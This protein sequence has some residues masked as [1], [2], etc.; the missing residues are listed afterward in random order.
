M[1]KEI[2][3]LR[4]KGLP[5]QAIGDKFGLS[6]E[7]VRQ[8]LL[9]DKYKAKRRE[10]RREYAKTPKQREYQ[11]EYDKTPK[12]RE[13]RREYDKTPKRREYQ[14]HRYH[15]KVNKQFANCNKCKEQ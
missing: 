10:Y 5:L 12:R 13:Y 4:D 11:R 14:R 3:Q 6:R 15:L 7:R 8:I 2:K 1:D 9:G